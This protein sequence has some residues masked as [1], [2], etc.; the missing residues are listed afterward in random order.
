MGDDGSNIAVLVAA[1]A[2]GDQAA[3]DEIVDRYTPLLVK[4][5]MKY[6]LTSGEME[7]VAQTVWLRLIE[8][9]GDLREP[10]ALPGWIATT[11]KR[12]AVRCAVSMARME[13]KD[14]HD[15][16][17]SSQLATE[18]ELGAEMMRSEL[19]TALL[20]GLAMLSARQRNLLTILS[21]EPPVSYAEISHRTGIPVGA[22]GPTRA[23]AL[24][25]LRRTPSVRAL[26]TTAVGAESKGARR[27]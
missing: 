9:L 20:E 17:W 4:I 25:R 21:A 19:Q 22:I 16:V 3:W 6:R 2:R 1:A 12:E 24:E 15:E 27:A 10:R 8:H 23:R 14:P 5:I 18:D 7:D 11:A 13:P 26:V